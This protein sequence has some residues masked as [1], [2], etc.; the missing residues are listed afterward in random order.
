CNSAVTLRSCTFPEVPGGANPT[1][2]P[3]TSRSIWAIP[4]SPTPGVPTPNALAMFSLDPNSNEAKIRGYW[5]VNA[6][7]PEGAL[8]NAPAALAARDTELAGRD[9]R[10]NA[11]ILIGNLASAE[12]EARRISQL[13]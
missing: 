13:V 4:A 9:I 5:F 10:A 2:V 1:Q 3:A 12:A 11:F 6:V 7:D 8:S